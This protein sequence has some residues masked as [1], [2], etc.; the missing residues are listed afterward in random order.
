MERTPTS[1]PNYLGGFSSYNKHKRARMSQNL[2]QPHRRA[3]T[4]RDWDRS[5]REEKRHLLSLPPPKR[6]VMVTENG[7]AANER[8]KA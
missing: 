1:S 2:Q 3:V 4:P 7:T 5:H 8:R 6:T